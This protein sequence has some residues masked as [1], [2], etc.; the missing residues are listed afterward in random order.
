MVGE[1]VVQALP[2]SRQVSLVRKLCHFLFSAKA[3]VKKKK[4]RNVDS[5]HCK[6]AIMLTKACSKQCSCTPLRAVLGVHM[7]LTQ[8]LLVLK[9][10][11]TPFDFPG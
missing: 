2:P 6:S 3:E 9:P 8:A 10:G 7:N 1:A 5:I 11:E 4:K